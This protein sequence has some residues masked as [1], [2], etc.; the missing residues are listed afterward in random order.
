MFAAHDLSD[1]HFEK[2][3][4]IVY[5]A[6]GISLKNGKE[7]LVRS[8]L[9]KR[10][11][12]LDMPNFD[13][14]MAYV[15]R[16]AG[17]SELDHL[18]D[19]MTT[20]KTN[21]FRE[22]EHF[23]FL[24]DTVLPGL[25]SRKLR[26]WTAACSSGEEPYTLAMVLRENMPDI[27]QRDV[28]IL[29]TDISQTM[30]TRARQGVYTAENL[31]GIPLPLLKKYLIARKPENGIGTTYQMHERIRRMVHVNWLNLIGHWPMKG[32]LD[33]IFCRNVMIYFDKRTQD[34]LIGRF[35][36]LLKTGG[37]LFVGHSEGLSRISHD[38]TYVRP[39]V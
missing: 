22:S 34:R 12:A 2:I 21:F 18:I 19:T 24:S 6:S 13:A 4:A 28:R 37:Y 39:A 27:D 25:S 14:Y 1:T 35:W 10:L 17:G 38:F 3:R 15:D 29:A 26:F 11:R 9:M 31:Q 7:A 32:P 8:R 33:V 20:N 16:D 36:H 5:K 23:R 30:L